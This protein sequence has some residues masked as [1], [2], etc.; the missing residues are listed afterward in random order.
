MR[1]LHLVEASGRAPDAG[2]EALL[3]CRALLESPGG[4]S[5][6]H[7]VWLIG[8]ESDEARA[9]RA[10]LR[11]ERLVSP[12]LGVP[13]LSWRGCRRAARTL[14]RPD[15]VVGWSVGAM[16]L[17]RLCFGGVPRV[18]VM[19]R[20]PWASAGWTAGVRSRMGFPGATTVALSEADG[21]AWRIA[22]ADDVRTAQYVPALP[23]E[24]TLAASRRAARERLD[25]D[26]ADVAVL[27]LADPPG[28]ADVRRFTFTMG[29]IY[30]MG[31]RVVGL[32][33]RWGAGD[34]TPVALQQRRRAA[35][36]VRAHGRRWG[37]IEWE[38]S[39]EDLL[40]ACDLAVCDLRTRRAA[41]GG[42]ELS[43][44]PVMIACAC[45]RGV[46]VIAPVIEAAERIRA[47]GWSIV[48]ARG[49]G[50]SGLAGAMLPLIDDP[51]VRR[52]ASVQARSIPSPPNDRTLERVV[53]DVC[54]E[55][56]DDSG[57]ETA[58]RP[59]SP[60]ISVA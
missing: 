52:G 21:A 8:T 31:G 48:P 16:A 18:G 22:G 7:D 54:R 37:M 42:P 15:V 32:T 33:P 25:L 30:T 34:R 44:G 12:V 2:E 1:I 6:H 49:E 58:R 26:E 27:L 46:P 51:A 20:G 11:V 5:A 43:A 41:E 13:E 9:R 55:L 45:T 56:V 59:G 38:G 29:L 40:A 24:E 60:A 4:A 36:L 39:M 10:G 53:L 28:A 47:L 57:T 50:T 17:G 19:I 14:A 35:R 3:A 23:D